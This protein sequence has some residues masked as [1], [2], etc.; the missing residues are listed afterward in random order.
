MAAQ[1]IINRSVISS[2]ISLIDW[3]YRMG[4]TDARSVSDEGLVRDFC[5]KTSEVGVFGFLSDYPTLIT[6]QE[7]ALRLL[8]KARMTSWN[9]MMARYMNRM[10]RYGQNFL[11][12]FLPLAQAW[13]CKGAK[14]YTNAPTGCDMAV[15]NGRTRVYW[16]ANGVRK[17]DNRRY[18]D[19]LQLETFVLERRDGAVREANTEYDAKKAGA[20]K[21]KHYQYF[22]TAIGLAL[23]TK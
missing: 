15:F 8:A 4:V 14:D 10:G 7:F 17:V 2:M 1:P 12:C 9:G 20:L 21:P 19:E 5:E 3:A 23:T 11:S 22:R 6:W 18:V 16:T 13:Y